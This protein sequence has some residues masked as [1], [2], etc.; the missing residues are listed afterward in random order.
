MQ[1]AL[2]QV[3]LPVVSA[4]SWCVFDCEAKRILTGHL[5]IQKRE[6][7]SLTKMMTFWV[8]WQVF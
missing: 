4:E 8:S 2:K 3:Q 7:A 1:R 5:A 6:V